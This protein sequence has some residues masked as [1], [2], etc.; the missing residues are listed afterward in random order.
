MDKLIPWYKCLVA[1]AE[2]QQ[3]NAEIYALARASVPAQSPLVITGAKPQKPGTEWE[4]SSAGGP[5][6]SAPP[7]DSRQAMGAACQQWLNVK[8]AEFC[9]RDFSSV[10]EEIGNGGAATPF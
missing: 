3:R 2:Q 1:I 6:G 10:F 4:S 7:A 8:Y 9:P 5:T